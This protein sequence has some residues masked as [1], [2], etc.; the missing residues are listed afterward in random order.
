MMWKMV[1][2][3]AVR[4][5]RTA[6]HCLKCNSFKVI[7]YTYTHT[8]IL[9]PKMPLHCLLTRFLSHFLYVSLSLLCHVFLFLLSF[10]ILSL[11][12]GNP[13]DNFLF[14][15]NFNNLIIKME[16]KR[17]TFC[18]R[19]SIKSHPT[20]KREIV[21]KRKKNRVI[22][23]HAKYDFHTMCVIIKFFTELL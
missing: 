7:T 6:L 17:E 1:Y 18:E 13:L 3:Q 2:A 8:H 11:L 10:R 20:T 21:W 9:Y 4:R 22:N 16:K 14:I 19:V 23:F 5:W 15:D 12:E